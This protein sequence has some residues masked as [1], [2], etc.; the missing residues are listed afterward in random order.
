M[1]TLQNRDYQLQGTVGQPFAQVSITSN[2]QLSS[3]Y[4]YGSTTG[5][6]QYLPLTRR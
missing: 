4:W 3:G 5:L 1:A 2:T 6:R